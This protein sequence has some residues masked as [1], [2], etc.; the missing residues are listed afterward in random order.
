[1]KQQPTL[2]RRKFENDPEPLAASYLTKTRPSTS[3]K[4]AEGIKKT[5]NAQKSTGSL[6]SDVSTLNLSSSMV[7]V[8]D[9]TSTKAP[10][11]D[12]SEVREP[13]VSR[14]AA[15]AAKVERERKLNSSMTS[16][17]MKTVLANA[18]KQ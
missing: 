12:R 1:M 18:K 9:D 15:A 8:D 16:K 5:M 14:A 17:D 3:T 13:V 11:S 10:M 2:T 6:H 4:L 7:I